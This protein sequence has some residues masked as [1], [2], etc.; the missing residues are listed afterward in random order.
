MVAR[1]AAK[2]KSR[3]AMFRQRRLREN[4]SKVLVKD[5]G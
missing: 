5:A 3:K 4:A 2:F 1:K